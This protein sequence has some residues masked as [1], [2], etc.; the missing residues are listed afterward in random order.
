MLAPFRF[1]DTAATRK[2]FDTCLVNSALT[3]AAELIRISSAKFTEISGVSVIMRLLFPPETV[4]PRD[5][6]DAKEATESLSS[7]LTRVRSA[8]TG[9]RSVTAAGARKT[10][11]VPPA[12]LRDALVTLLG[13]SSRIS[14]LLHLTSPDVKTHPVAWRSTPERPRSSDDDAGE[15]T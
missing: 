2:I 9:V 12:V 10:P 3:S 5:D 6:R 1:D 11:S 4:D 13:G 14:V 15:P 8:L 7:D